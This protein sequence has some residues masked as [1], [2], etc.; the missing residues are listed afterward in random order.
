[1]TGDTEA[2]AVSIERIRSETGLGILDSLMVWAERNQCEI[3]TVAAMVK[4]DP[5]LKAKLMLES[6][7]LNL[8]TV[9]AAN[10]LF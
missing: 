8:V 1:M 9:K 6:Q 3:E 5:L 7:S 4:K 10:T 2:F